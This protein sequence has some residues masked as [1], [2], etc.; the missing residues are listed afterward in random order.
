MRISPNPSSGI[1]TVS[2]QTGNARITAVTDVQGR[3]VLRSD[4]E[5]N[6]LKTID[7]R[8]LASGIYYIKV[9]TAMGEGVLKVVKE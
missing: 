3:V 8:E 7:L 6:P 2:S 1:F 5:S 4:G 9:A